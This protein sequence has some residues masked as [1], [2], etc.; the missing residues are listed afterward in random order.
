MATPMWKV[1]EQRDFEEAKSRYE[2]CR[3]NRWK[4]EWWEIICEIYDT[5]AEWSKKYILDRATKIIRIVGEVVKKATRRKTVEV[6]PTR[7]YYGDTVIDLLDGTEEKVNLDGDKTYLF[8]FCEDEAGEV[9]SF[10]KIG[11]TA[12]K[13]L[14]RLKQE[15]RYY[16]AHGFN[17]TRV[18][19]C[20]V[21]VCADA[22]SEGYESAL[23]A[24]LIRKYPNT[25]KKNDRFF[26]V[27]IP[28]SEFNNLCAEYAAS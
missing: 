21:R 4:S 1:R 19:I 16:N 27:D 7:I 28:T 2:D 25:W 23:R 13:V 14:D 15:I 17:I 22:P 6:S 5:C 3:S 9:V 12:K 11:T 24:A 18:F 26:G 20:E 8:K 10:S